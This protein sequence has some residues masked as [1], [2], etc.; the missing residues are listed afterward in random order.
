[1]AL[2]TKNLIV[3]WIMATLLLGACTTTKRYGDA[4]LR[5]SGFFLRNFSPG[6]VQ[7]PLW[8]PEFP[9]DRRGRYIFRVDRLPRT[10]MPV[11][12]SVLLIR[13]KSGPTNPPWKSAEFLVAVRP[14]HGVWLRSQPVAMTRIAG[15]EDYSRN[16]FINTDWKAV[17][18]P[19]GQA[20]Y[21]VAIEVIRP[22]SG[23]GDRAI[24]TNY[25]SEYADEMNGEK[26]RG[27]ESDGSTSSNRRTH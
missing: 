11:Y 1:M 10:E 27:I 25:E 24:L 15:S 12:P 21:E 26:R 2:R 8:L 7:D 18:A 14:A 20:S 16:A 23:K 4:R 5:E 3:P 17:L 13:S 9:I 22:S 6:V 19:D